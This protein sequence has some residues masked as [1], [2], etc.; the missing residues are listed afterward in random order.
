MLNE[1][2]D[3]RNL[4]EVSISFKSNNKDYIKIRGCGTAP[5]PELDY[6]YGEGSNYD[7]AYGMDSP[8]FPPSR[9]YEQAYCTITFN[10]TPVEN[11]LTWLQ[12]N[13]TKK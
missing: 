8:N 13:G 10:A 4:G 12:A 2:I 3:S 11:L 7:V 5:S 6:F 1:S 9:W